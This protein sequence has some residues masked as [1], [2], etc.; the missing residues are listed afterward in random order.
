[1]EKVSYAQ[2]SDTDI[3]NQ[4]WGLIV[5][6][7]LLQEQNLSYKSVSERPASHR[8]PVP[9]KHHP[10]A[11]FPPS[12]GWHYGGRNTP[13]FFCSFGPAAVFIYFIA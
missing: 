12:D 2:R 4:E 1:M 8:F 10:W 5:D 7:I 13:G 6:L 9:L 3:Y 11:A